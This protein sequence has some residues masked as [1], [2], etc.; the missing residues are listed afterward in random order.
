MKVLI[1]G[2]DPFGEESINPS[3]ELIRQMS[4]VI[5][6]C[7]IIKKEIPTVFNKSIDILESIIEKEQPDIVICI[8]QAGGECA[9]RI[10]RFAL[11]LNEARIQDNEGKQ[12]IDEPIK[13]DG[14]IGYFSTLPVKAILKGLKENNIPATLSYTAG[15]FVCNNLM[16]GL[17][18]LIDTKYPNI[19][20][21]FIHVPY[22]P[23]QVLDKK[24]MPSMSLDM[25]IKSIELAIKIIIEND[26][27]IIYTAGTLH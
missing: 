8:G 22:L 4:D 26:R 19:R 18:Y 15:T 14:K 9:I 27:D 6:E 12:P 10:E 16:Y 25:M 7:E 1:T 24:N 2:F 23:E 5:C 21:G 13:V 17:M 20:G 11:N 3:Y